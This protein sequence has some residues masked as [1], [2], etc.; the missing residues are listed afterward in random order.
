M[1]YLIL[2]ISLNLLACSKYSGPYRICLES[3]QATEVRP[4]MVGK[5]PQQADLKPLNEISCKHTK[6]RELSGPGDSYDICELAPCLK[7]CKGYK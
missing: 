5:I 4:Q 2:L 3:H 7:R 1:K 6:V